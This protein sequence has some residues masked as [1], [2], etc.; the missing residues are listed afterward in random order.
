MSLWAGVEPATAHE[1]REAGP[2][3]RAVGPVADLEG[4]EGPVGRHR[5]IPAEPHGDGPAHRRVGDGKR[6]SLPAAPTECGHKRR[7]D[8]QSGGE[9]TRRRQGAVL[10]ERGR[11]GDAVVE[12]LP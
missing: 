8:E 2:E 11:L 4:A 3:A 7:G 1:A 6:Y 5:R 10:R 9:G 12:V